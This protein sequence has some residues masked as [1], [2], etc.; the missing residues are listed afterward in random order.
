M[1]TPAIVR[2]LSSSLVALAL[3]TSGCANNE[4]AAKPA[5]DA[6]SSA[7]KSSDA[8]AEPGA[9]AGKPVEGEGKPAVAPGDGGSGAKEYALE[10]VPAAAKVGEPSQVSI[11]VVPQGPW[12]MNL[13]YPT[14][15]EVVAPAGT[16]VAK[17]SLAKA[18]AVTLD[19]QSCEFA[20]SFTPEDAGTKKFTGEFKF[21]ICQDEACVPKTETLEFDVTV[22]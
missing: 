9:I 22:E 7:P 2:V 20:V 18:D 10:I 1:P 3:L 12:H 5:G 14:K 19:E 4:P 13:E 6:N 8:P 16:T 21:A 17:P 15:L 11:K